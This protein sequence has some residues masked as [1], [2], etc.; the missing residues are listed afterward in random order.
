M[1]APGG[2]TDVVTAEFVRS[3][4]RPVHHRRRHHVVTAKAGVS[5]ERRTKRMRTFTWTPH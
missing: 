3:R 2:W 1:L 4:V 5:R